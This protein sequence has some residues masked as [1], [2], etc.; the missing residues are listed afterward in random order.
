MTIESVVGNGVLW[1]IQQGNSLD[2]LRSM[3]DGCVQT[4]ATSPPYYNLRD[5]GVLP[6]VWPPESDWRDL[7][8]SSINEPLPD[9]E[10]EWG[11]EHGRPGSEY[12]EGLGGMCDGR[13]DKAKIRKSFRR[14]K[15]EVAI[16]KNTT[17]AFCRRCGAWRGTFGLEPTPQLYVWHAVLIFREVRRVM[18]D[19]ATLFLNLGDSYA[20]TGYGKGT[21]HF[22]LRDTPGAMKP[23]TDCRSA[24]LK[25]KDLCGIPWRVA[26]ALQA[27]GWWL[28]DAII[29]AKGWLT[30]DGVTEGNPM[31]GSHEDRCTS[32]YE[33]VF[34]FTKKRQYFWDW[35]AIKSTSGA[36]PRNVWRINP[37]GDPSAHFATFPPAL[38]ERCI[39]AGTSEKGC[40]PKCGKPWVRV[41]E[42]PPNP[43]KEFN[44]GDDLTGGAP[45]MGGNRQT[46]K[47]LHRNNG[48]A[49][50]PPAITTG[51]RPGCKCNAGEPV[52][53]IVL[54][55]FCGSGTTGEV[56]LKLGRRF[57]GIEINPD[58]I[59]DIANLRVERGETG[60]TRKQQKHGQ[61]T[62]LDKTK[63]TCNE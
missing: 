12:R 2:V 19:D 32:A 9:C 6:S 53:C 17:G 38:P 29:W 49:Q 30:E 50:G 45:G 24:G 31:P 25:P 63:E 57:I 11:G 58:Y 43:S 42:R 21:G 35:F 51:W 27:D 10:H 37:K 44:V 26:L 14:D 15:A 47:G 7:D 16:R 46:S 55:P 8:G 60:L 59:K 28:R 20:G 36:R 1:Y 23:K 41:V 39:K 62:L 61:T 34:Q 40:C 52:P 5:Y 3:P 18:R 4:V 33:F 56:A 22:S 13:E 54:D 48:N